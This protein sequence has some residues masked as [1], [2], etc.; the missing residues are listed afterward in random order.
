[1]Q[2]IDSQRLQ[3]VR[4]S[5]GL[6]RQALARKANVS[7]R[8]IARIESPSG[9]AKGVRDNTMAQLSGALG[10]S[11]AVLTGDEPLLGADMGDVPKDALLD[12]QRLRA[13]RKGKR[14]SRRQLA[15]RSKVSQRQIARIESSATTVRSTTLARL[16]KAL[17][18]KVET[19]VDD[20]RIDPRPSAAPSTQLGFKV[21][22]Q[23]RLAYDLV[24]HRYGPSRREII[25]LAPLLFTLLAEGSLAWRRQCLDEVEEAMKRLSDLGE[26]SQLYFT[27][28]LPHAEEGY[29]M[30]E[31]SIDENDL[32][33]DTVRDE[34]QYT[35]LSGFNDDHYAVTPFA[36]YLRKLG[37]DLRSSGKVDFSPE[38]KLHVAVGELDVIW[39]ADPYQVCRDELNEITGGSESACSALAYGDVQLSD[40]PKELMTPDAKEKRVA[41]LEEMGAEGAKQRER[42]VEKLRE[43]W[44]LNKDLGPS[45]TDVQPQEGG[46]RHD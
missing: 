3:Q 19:L 16:A 11:V 46:E 30:E 38:T 44:L 13:L 40:I 15:E 25:E 21:S 6:S 23:L 22:P 24:S 12:P 45:P 32:L 4:N 34:A 28:C 20:G 18:E 7:E 37:K 8:Q 41:W 36:D 31:V 5:K 33:G 42:M 27:K 9:G 17:G 10:V 2:T 26:K 43:A 35:W 39:G 1:M 29:F 14:M